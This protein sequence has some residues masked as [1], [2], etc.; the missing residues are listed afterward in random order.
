M[1]YLKLFLSFLQIGLL[2]IG[3]GYAAMP[4]IQ[5]QVVDTNNWLTMETFTDLI[6]ISEMTPGPIAIN[7]AT[8][9]GMQVSGILGAIVATIG[10]V[11]PSFVIVITLAYFYNKFI[12]SAIM[13]GIL[14]GLRPIV[15][16]LI[17]S[18]GLSIT[19]TAL[20]A[21]STLIGVVNNFKDINVFSVILFGSSL[22]I[23][24]KFKPNPILV[25]FG[26][27]LLGVIFFY[28]L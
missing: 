17:A 6:T 3:G 23:L 27:G 12:S 21:Q 18:A 4:L 7:A 13:D 5:K 10:L 24:R 16:S 19:F 25:M 15:V 9:V 28:F 20:W 11:L 22:F 14:K 26:C 1:I 8:F 2:S